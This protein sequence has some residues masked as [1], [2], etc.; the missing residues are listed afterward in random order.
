MPNGI[1]KQPKGRKKIHSLL[2]ISKHHTLGRVMNTNFKYLKTQD[3]LNT[4]HPSPHNSSLQ[5]G[6]TESAILSCP[7]LLQEL[8]PEG[9]SEHILI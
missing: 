8:T 7:W 1:Q 4:H 6:K 3:V 2:S 5:F 9:H